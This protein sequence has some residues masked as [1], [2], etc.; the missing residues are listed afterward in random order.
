MLHKLRVLSLGVFESLSILTFIVLLSADSEVSI[1]YWLLV[2]AG[3]IVCVLTS[4][5]LFD[6]YKTLS[7]VRPSLV[8]VGAFMYDKLHIRFSRTLKKCY[9]ILKHEGSYKKCYETSV[10]VYNEYLEE[11]K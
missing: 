10:A 9:K 8:C 3:F 11:V 6:P 1:F 5:L 7:I 2:L 4:A